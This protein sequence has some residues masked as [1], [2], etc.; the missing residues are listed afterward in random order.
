ML[1]API[2]DLLARAPEVIGD[3]RAGRYRIEVLLPAFITLVAA[4]AAAKAIVTLLYK[5]V[6]AA[7]FGAIVVGAIALWRTTSPE[8]PP[9]VTTR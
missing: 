9:R 5:L 2:L 3:L 8:R 4:V 7:A 6:K 1:I